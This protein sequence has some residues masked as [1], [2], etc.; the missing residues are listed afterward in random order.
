MI[1][2]IDLCVGILNKKTN[3]TNKEYAEYLHPKDTAGFLVYDFHCPYCRNKEHDV[4]RFP[5]PT[6]KFKDITNYK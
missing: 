6:S 3:M 5:P 1:Y 4:N 2:I